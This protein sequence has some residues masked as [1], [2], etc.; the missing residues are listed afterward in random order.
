MARQNQQ[1]RIGDVVYNI[2]QFPATRGNRMLVRLVKMFGP[3]LGELMA[4]DQ[5]KLT[6]PDQVKKIGGALQSLSATVTEDEWDHLTKDLLECVTV[7]ATSVVEDFDLRFQGKLMHLYS[8]LAQV[9]M[10]NYEDF[11]GGLAAK[12][13]ARQGVAAGSESTSLNT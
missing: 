13:K 9:I 2:N 11:F 6:E 4:V 3:A 1:K 5:K 12:I 8:L 10:V 7:G